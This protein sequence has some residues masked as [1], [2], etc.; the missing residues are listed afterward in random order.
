MG[1]RKIGLGNA[2][3]R[4]RKSK[5]QFA[6]EAVLLLCIG[7]SLLLGLKKWA[8][9]SQIFANIF[10]KPWGKIS[11]MIENGAWGSPDST[12]NKH[13]HNPEKVAT[14]KQL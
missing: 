2:E 10:T 13:P 5:G 7:L 11:G 14:V 9:D 3:F 12:R 1:K 4:K 6:I 8:N